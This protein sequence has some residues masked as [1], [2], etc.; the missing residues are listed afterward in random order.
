MTS[1][2]TNNVWRSL[3]KESRRGETRWQYHMRATTSVGL[4]RLNVDCYP[5]TK[6]KGDELETKV[7][8]DELEIPSKRV[9]GSRR[10]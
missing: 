1:I 7:K 9:G 4:A 2:S 8:G 10:C 3:L 6:V 5:V